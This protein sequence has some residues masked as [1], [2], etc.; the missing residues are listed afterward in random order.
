MP[1]QH[2]EERDVSSFPNISSR[3]KHEGGKIEL[4]LLDVA[5]AA[6]NDHPKKIRGHYQRKCPV[7]RA[8]ARLAELEAALGGGHWTIRGRLNAT[9]ASPGETS[10]PVEDYGEYATEAEARAAALANPWL[11]ICEIIYVDA[12]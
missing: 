3:I 9:D 7:C 4:A 2:I 12:T 8:L 11:P 5:E 1:D 10:A 6:E